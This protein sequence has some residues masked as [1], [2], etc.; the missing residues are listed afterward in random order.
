MVKHLITSGCSFTRLRHPY[1]GDNI[2]ERHSAKY[3]TETYYTHAHHLA[4]K[5]NLEL[6]NEGFPTFD[7]GAIVNTIIQRVNKL[8]K[9]G[10]PVEEIFVVAQFTSSVRYSFLVDKNLSILRDYDVSKVGIGHTANYLD[11]GESYYDNGYAFL[12]SGSPPLQN[13][14]QNRFNKIYD[15]LL[16]ETNSTFLMLKNIHHLQTFLKSKGIKYVCFFMLNQLVDNS[17]YPFNYHRDFRY[18]NESWNDL[19]FGDLASKKFIPYNKENVEVW[20]N[21]NN[22]YWNIFLDDIDWKPFWFFE[23]EATK[24]SGVFEWSFSKFDKDNLLYTWHE[25]ESTQIKDKNELIQWL[26]KV[27]YQGYH[28]S[29][30]LWNTFVEEELI[31]H[32]NKT[33]PNIF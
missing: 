23:N 9:K 25:E 10:T 17:Y 12:G 31:P 5:Y 14:A 30:E 33:H 13:Q 16:D 24:Y 21:K 8:L 3:D 32:I 22:K 4:K 18:Y 28:P 11:E 29:A 15:G 20:N 19:K 7:N 27:G 6:H 26:N 2:H 1:T